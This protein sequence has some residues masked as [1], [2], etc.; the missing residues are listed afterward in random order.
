MASEA[1]FPPLQTSDANSN[2]SEVAE[3][4]EEEMPA[5]AESAQPS[6]WLLDE[7]KLSAP[8]LAKGTGAITLYFTPISKHRESSIIVSHQ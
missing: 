8:F 1:Q 6:T 5:S 7:W 4:W 2:L 3:R